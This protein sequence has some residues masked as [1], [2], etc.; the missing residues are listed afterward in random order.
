MACAFVAVVHFVL[1]TFVPPDRAQ[2]WGG[3]SF[4][5]FAAL[6]LGIAGAGAPSAAPFGNPLPWVVVAILGGTTLWWSTALAAWWVLRVPWTRPRRIFLRVAVAAASLRAL[7][8]L[9]FLAREPSAR[10]SWEAAYDGRSFLVVPAKVMVLVIIGVIVADGVRAARRHN[11]AGLLALIGGVPSFA[12]MGREIL[13]ALGIVHGVGLIGLVGLPFMLATSFVIGMRYVG[14]ARRRTAIELGTQ[15]GGYRLIRRLASGGMG[16]LFLAAR[17]GPGGF[18]RHL[19][20]KRLRAGL[21]EDLDRLLREARLTARL[22]HPNIVAVHDVG[23]IEAGIGPEWFIAMEY[24]PGVDL[25]RIRDAAREQDALVPP[26]IASL[27]G[28]RV[29]DGLAHAHEASVVHR[30][31]SPHNV[32]I[33]FDGEVKIVD[34]GVAVDRA[35]EGPDVVAGKLE[36]FAPELF[37]GAAPSPASDQYALGITLYE[38][39]A[40]ARPFRGQNAREVAARQR[41]GIDAVPGAPPPLAAVVLRALS[42]DPAARFPDCEALSAALREA[43]RASTPDLRAWVRRICLKDWMRERRLALVEGIDD[44]SRG[45]EPLR[46]LAAARA[47]ET[48]RR[49]AGGR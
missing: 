7:D 30:D 3:I 4:A 28:E 39:L 46:P 21:P 33:T 10:A 32:M 41:E 29:A 16:D 18:E 23:R 22:R 34:F 20:L 44:A 9:V 5:A 31:V 11:V 36:Y 15:I 26:E 25:S 48:F 37:H 14:A 17:V 45:E 42:T 24:L 6:D 38:L 12:F 13:I 49:E 35:P 27:V 19:A 8:L 2:L 43:R 1:W 47:E 40:G